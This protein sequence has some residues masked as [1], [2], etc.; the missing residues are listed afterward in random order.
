MLP[1][2]ESVMSDRILASGVYPVDFTEYTYEALGRF[3]HFA[4]ASEIDNSSSAAST[5]QVF[6]LYQQ[7]T[8]RHLYSSNSKEIDLFSGSVQSDYINE[9]IAYV[10]GEGAGQD[11]HHFFPPD[12]GLYFYSANTSKQDGLLV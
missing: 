9:G 5:T 1:P 8:G 7:S 12:T 11:L 4:P 10:V 6:C 2:E 3:W